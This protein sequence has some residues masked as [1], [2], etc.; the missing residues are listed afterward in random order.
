MTEP[1]ERVYEI[2]TQHC[3]KKVKADEILCDS[4]ESLVIFFL[5]GEIVAAWNLKHIEGFFIS[6]ERSK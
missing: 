2:H 5:G 1:K 3:S 6:E 4:E